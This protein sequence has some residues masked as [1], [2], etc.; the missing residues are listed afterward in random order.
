MCVSRHSY[1]STCCSRMRRGKLGELVISK[2]HEREK[3][4]FPINCA[5]QVPQHSAFGLTCILHLAQVT[6]L[7]P[8]RNKHRM[9]IY[10]AQNISVAG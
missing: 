9:K 8:S 4:V 1:A 6:Y 7:A 2:A 3:A 5:C 10:R